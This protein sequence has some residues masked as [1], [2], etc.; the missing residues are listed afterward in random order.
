MPR[1]GLIINPTSGKG[2]GKVHGDRAKQTLIDGGADV[3]DLSAA[4]FDEALANGRAAVA[5]EG[6]DGIVVAGADN[7]D[8]VVREML[9]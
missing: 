3:I 9:H 5:N 8:Y 4:S 6:L 7:C 1:L 2:N